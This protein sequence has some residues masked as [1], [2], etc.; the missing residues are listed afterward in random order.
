MKIAVAILNFNGVHLLKRFLPSVVAYSKE[1]E[2][3]IIDNASSDNSKE[4]V[5]ENFPSIK[6]IQLERNHGF[7]SGY[8]LGLKAIDADVFVLLNSDVEVTPNWLNPVLQLLEK[9]EVAVAQ[10]KI[11]SIKQPEKFEFAGAAGGFIDQLGYPLCRGRVF[12]DLEKDHGQY[13]DAIQ[14]AWATGCCMFIKSKVFWE[15]GGFDDDFFA[16][17]E[18]IDLCWRIRNSGKEVWYCPNSTIYHIGGGTL[19]TN[20]PRKTYLNFRNNLWMLLK[21]LPPYRWLPIIF[22]RLILDGIAAFEFL[23][24]DGWGHFF[25]VIRAH[26]SFYRGFAKMYRKRRPGITHYYITKFLVWKYFILGKRT[27]N[28]VVIKNQ[29]P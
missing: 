20:H 5:N 18:E 11:L 29:T 8:N 17:M 3:Y 22:I 10:P 25:A 12:F 28:E 1:A 27:F 14:I 4:W 16:H 6:W 23:I 7:A 2:I 13:N 9:E 21:N 19:I 15:M 24:T 26:L